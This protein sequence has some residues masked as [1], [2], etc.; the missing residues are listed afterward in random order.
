MTQDKSY[1]LTDDEGMLASEPAVA[2][3]SN[4]QS[5]HAETSYI[6]TGMPQ[7]VDEALADIAEGEREFER[8]ETFSHREVMQM[9]W[10]KIDSYAGKIQ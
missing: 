7:S 8:N 9:I 10:T 5:A 4:I 1:L 3:V 6:P 2:A